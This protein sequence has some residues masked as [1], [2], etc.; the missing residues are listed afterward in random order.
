MH[1]LFSLI[2]LASAARPTVA[3]IPPVPEADSPSWPG[4]VI[5]DH[6]ESRILVHSRYNRKKMAR[7]YPLNVF[8]WRQ[9]SSAARAEGIP[10]D[11]PINAKNVKTLS[12]QLGA[13]YLLSGRYELKGKQV[14]LRWS[15]WSKGKMLIDK[16]VESDLNTLSLTSEEIALKILA[17]AG[18]TKRTHGSK[19]QPLPLAAARSYGIAMEILAKQ[20]L[21]PQA[22]VVL[23]QNDLSTALDGFSAATDAKPDFTSAWVA[24]GICSA[25]LED[26]EASEMALVQAMAHAGEFNPQT[27]LGLYYLYERQG[28]S[29]DGIKVLKEATEAHPGFLQGLGYLGQAESRTLHS[30]DALET[31]T[32]YTQRVPKNPWARVKRAEQLSRIG[33]RDQAIKQTRKILKDFPK[34]AMVFMALASRQI[35][36]GKYKKAKKSATKGLAFNPG[37]PGLL[38]RLSYIEIENGDPKKAKKLAEEAVASLN[39]SRGGSLSGYAWLNLGHAMALLGEKADAIQALKNAK[40]LGLSAEALHMLRRDQ[41]IREFMNDPENPIKYQS[42]K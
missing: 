3:I 1:I 27:S 32:L 4:L 35:D 23:S 21:D 7:V 26:F 2:L 10:L 20:S 9:V 17:K 19:L 36:A 33:E 12:R 29:K 37:H 14:F 6:I 13:K 28:K 30:H 42:L 24:R 8:G 11:Q 22:R 31:F 38:T 5:A 16:S 18:E 39:R 41:R 34:S 15:L 40:K 25:M